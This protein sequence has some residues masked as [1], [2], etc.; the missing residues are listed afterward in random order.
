M[1]YESGVYTNGAKSGV[2]ESYNENGDVQSREL[3]YNDIIIES[4][5]YLPDNVHIVN[6]SYH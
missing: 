6:F 5:T 3:Y 4:E 1:L 2:W